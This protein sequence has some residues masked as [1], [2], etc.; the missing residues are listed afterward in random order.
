MLFL[1]RLCEQSD[2][3]LTVMCLNNGLQIALHHSNEL[4]LHLPRS[5]L[6]C[7]AL[8]LSHVVL[9]LRFLLLQIGSEHHIRRY[10]QFVDTVEL[11]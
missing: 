1:E 8:E 4:I 5:K 6:S 9:N 7:H 2:A 11:V 3:L 10:E